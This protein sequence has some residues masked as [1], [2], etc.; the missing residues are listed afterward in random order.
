MANHTCH[1]VIKNVYCALYRLIRVMRT[2]SAA[3][4]IDGVM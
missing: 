3:I 2:D 4:D 1:V